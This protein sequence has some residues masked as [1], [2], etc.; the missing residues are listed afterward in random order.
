MTI[1]QAGQSTQ[2]DNQAVQ[3]AGKYQAAGKQSSQGDPMDNC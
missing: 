1:E 3:A 2:V